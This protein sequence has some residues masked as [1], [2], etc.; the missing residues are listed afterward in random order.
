MACC[1]IGSAFGANGLKLR[2]KVAVSSRGMVNSGPLS[3]PPAALEPPDHPVTASAPASSSAVT[4]LP[5]ARP[6]RTIM[7]LSPFVL[8]LAGE[9]LSGIGPVGASHRRAFNKRAVD[10]HRCV[11]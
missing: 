2:V 1:V 9:D 6:I 4:L 7:V 8:P 11:V 3:E 5:R 10:R